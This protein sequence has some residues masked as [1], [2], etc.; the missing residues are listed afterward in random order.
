MAPPRRKSPAI[1][2]TSICSYSRT[3]IPTIAA[4]P[5]HAA[6]D[7]VR[8]ALL[9][10]AGTSLHGWAAIAGW[11][12]D[13]DDPDKRSEV[14]RAFPTFN[15]EERACF[16]AQI[17]NSPALGKTLLADLFLTVDDD[18]VRERCIEI[19]PAP[20]NPADNA[21]YFYLIEDWARY[22]ENDVAFR[23]LLRTFDGP[24]TSLQVRLIAAAAR[25]G[26]EEWLTAL[27]PDDRFGEARPGFGLSDWTGQFQAASR[28]P[29]G[30]A[31][32]WALAQAAPLA[33]LPDAI[34]RLEAEGFR[35]RDGEERA[36]FD[37]IAAF[38]HESRLPF[39]PVPF[40]SALAI[41][42]GSWVLSG[43]GHAP[44]IHAVRGG[45]DDRHHPEKRKPLDL[46][47]RAGGGEVHTPGPDGAGRPWA[48][49]AYRDAEGEPY[50]LSEA[51]PVLPVSELHE[52]SEE[53]RGI[54]Q[55]FSDSLDIA[56]GL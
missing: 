51:L 22:E 55:S 1:N 37:R 47:A 16:F 15:R 32:Q 45:G 35:A 3:Q 11:I 5:E 2:N 17:E 36:L 42:C 46:P 52:M 48:D 20:S 14:I 56:V 53:R 31:R 18:A 28:Q 21:V 38:I 24:D 6:N 27:H 40:E 39:P 43:R 29:D 44:G 12:A 8:A 41:D 54:Y 9:K 50:A 7:G 33:V 30:P 25:S 13:A 19:D 26:D 49:L 4:S 10:S 23:A 34:Q